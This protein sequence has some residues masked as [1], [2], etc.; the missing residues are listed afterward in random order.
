MLWI[1]VLISSTLPAKDRVF[2]IQPSTDLLHMSERGIVLDL[3][4]IGGER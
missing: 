4:I 1:T 3:Q 2:T